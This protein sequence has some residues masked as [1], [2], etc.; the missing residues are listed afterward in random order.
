MNRRELLQA[1][2][3]SSALFACQGLAKAARIGVGHTD[4]SPLDRALGD[5]SI[6]VR[7]PLAACAEAGGA[8]VAAL[9]ARCRNPFYLNEEA[10]LT[11]TFGWVGAWSTQPSGRAVVARTAT[12]VARAIDF[13][14]T[15]G[16]RL[17]V[18]GGRA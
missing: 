7:S 18:K 16:I 15:A 10:G 9:L 5:R 6:T 14:R 11:Q 4:W 1:L 8:G 13:A 2:T 17:V 12:D 3:T